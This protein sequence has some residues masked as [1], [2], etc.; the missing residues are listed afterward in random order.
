MK[1]LQLCAAI[2][3]GGYLALVPILQPLFV[4]HN[5]KCVCHQPVR[6][7]ESRILKLFALLTQ[8]PEKTYE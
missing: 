1:I 7:V 8:G 5:S 4:V 3:V 2:V 6:L